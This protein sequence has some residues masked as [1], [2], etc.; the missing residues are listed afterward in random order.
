[1]PEPAGGNPQ[2][3]ELAGADQCIGA[4]GA[5]KHA[6]KGLSRWAGQHRR[7]ELNWERTVMGAGPKWRTATPG[8]I[9]TADVFTPEANGRSLCLAEKFQDMQAGCQF[10]RG[11]L[12]ARSTTRTSM[13]N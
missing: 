12:S 7:A 1:M 2:F 6:R 5:R 9:R 8:P 4:A 3:I 13:G 11:V 10:P